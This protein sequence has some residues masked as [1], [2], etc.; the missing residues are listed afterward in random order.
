MTAETMPLTRTAAEH[1]G[2]DDEQ[3]IVPGV[4]RGDADQQGE[5][6]VDETFASHLIVQRIANPACHHAA[7]QIRNGGDGNHSRQQQRG[8]GEDG[9]G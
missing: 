7:R 3:Q 9:G 1:G 6:Q 5:D 2:D 4:E 8:G